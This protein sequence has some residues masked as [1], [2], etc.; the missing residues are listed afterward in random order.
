MLLAA[1]A[2]F[3]N[4]LG[5]GFALDDQWFIADNEVV[6]E[7]LYR[8]AFTEAAWPGAREGTGNYRPVTLSSFAFEWSLWGGS[9][10]G[11]HLVSLLAHVGVSLLVLALLSRFVG[12]LAALP[13]AAIFAVHPVHSE[14]VANVMGRAELYAALAFLAACLLY[15]DGRWASARARGMRLAGLVALFWIA[16]GAKEIAVTLPGMLVVLEVYRRSE[17][18]LRERLRGEALTYLALFAALAVYVLVRWGVLGDV[19]GES[20]APGLVSLDGTGRMLTALTVWP[21]YLRLMVFPLDLSADYSP[22]V[23]LTT[24]T[25]TLEVV[26]GGLLLM[27]AVAAAIGLRRRAPVAAVGFAWFVVAIS[28]VSNLVVRSDI[29]L[30]ERTLYLPSVG[31]AFLVSAL[32]LH[33]LES[34]HPWMRRG[35]TI[36]AIAAGSA[37]LVRTTTRNPTWLDTFTALSTLAEEHPESWFSQRTRAT[38]LTRVGAFEEAA[39]AYEAALEIAPDHYQLLVDAAVFFEARGRPE[40]ADDLLARAMVLLPAHLAA[41]RRHAEHLL[42]RGDGRGAH[43]VALQGLA[44]AGSDREL[45]ALVSESYVA[46]ADLGAATR[47]RA[48]SIAAEPTAVG[49]ARLG[50]LLDAMG[51]PLQAAEARA[52]ATRLTSRTEGSR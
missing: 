20:A 38:G 10:F 1:T 43:R 8:Q 50:D 45:W 24:T 3:A 29:L 11:F 33:V 52:Q 47:A 5:N 40:R 28:P 14:A 34:P 32:A 12:T 7:G 48:A 30:A 27:S 9:T 19:T 42:L 18:P 17:V 39:G 44:L 6:T 51:R 23:L 16:A 37:L 36:L 49:W 15:L 21:H 26:V 31:L 41:Y 13:G 25:V 35:A 46:K 2:A 4:S 22:A